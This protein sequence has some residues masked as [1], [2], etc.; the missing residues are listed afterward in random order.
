MPVIDLIFKFEGQVKKF[1]PVLFLYLIMYFVRAVIEIR[2]IGGKRKSVLLYLLVSFFEKNQK[3]VLAFQ[4]KR[5]YND[6][7]SRCPGF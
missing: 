1:L 5:G 3:K 6:K 7:Q 2:G 4:K